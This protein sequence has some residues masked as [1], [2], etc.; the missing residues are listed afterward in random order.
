M[1]A[2]HIRIAP[3]GSTSEFDPTALR[4]LIYTQGTQN[5]IEHVRVRAGPYGTDILAF[6]DGDDPEEATKALHQIVNRTIAGTPA[7]RR[8]RII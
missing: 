1:V 2:A 3:L 7:L 4:D 8:W 5:G 6:I